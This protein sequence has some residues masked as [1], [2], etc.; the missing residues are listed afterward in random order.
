[1]KR[2]FEHSVFCPYR[3]APIGAHSDIQFGKISGFA[4]DRG[5][6]VYYNATDDGKFILSSANF[7]GEVRFNSAAVP[8]MKQ[9]DWADYLRG[10]VHVLSRKHTVEHG[11]DAFIEGTMPVGGLSSSAAVTI[12]FLTA[13]CKANNITLTPEELIDT[14]LRAENEYV[15]VKCGRMDQSCEV[16]ARKDKL[17]FVDTLDGSHELIEPAECMKPYEIAVFFSGVE[18]TLVG[19]AYNMRVD[20]IQSAAYALQAFAGMEY[21]GF[22]DKRLRHIDPEI[23]CKYADR[24]PDNWR[25][26]AEHWYS[27]QERVE[28]GVEAFRRG[29]IEAFGKL[30]FESG[31]SSIYSYETGSPELKKLYDIMLTTDGIYGGRFSGAGFKGSCIALVDPAFKQSI[32]EKVT[33]E[34]LNEF[35]ALAGKF[36]VYF[37]K[38]S[39]GV[40]L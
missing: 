26:R 5:I 25:K 27:E 17:L 28:K 21:G 39:D 30:S 31:N 11:I 4:L 38:S 33:R 20:E 22:A 12:S 19:S 9:G 18:R 40:Q 15:G 34:Y 16:Y 36:K 7:D 6:T 24:L 35:P 14:A 13:V 2:E 32:E 8:E 29:D 1:M 23:F 37:C 10:A 3:V